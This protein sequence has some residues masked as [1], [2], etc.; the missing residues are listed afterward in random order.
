MLLVATLMLPLGSQAQ[1]LPTPDEA[2]KLI[3]SYLNTQSVMISAPGIPSK[4][5]EMSLCAEDPENPENAKKNYHPAEKAGWLRMIAFGRALEKEGFLTLE[6]GS[7]FEDDFYNRRFKFTGY[8][9]H[10]QNEMNSYVAVMPQQG[11]VLLK[12]GHVGVGQIVSVKAL[13]AEDKKAQ[14]SYTTV[15]IDR[16]PWFTQ[17]VEQ[18]TAVSSMLGG[19]EQVSLTF[20]DGKWLIDDPVFLATVKNPVADFKY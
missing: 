7:F 6:Q 18:F 3:N 11:R 5:H 15:L 16:A 9:M 14:V 12:V 19:K 1:A 8:L 4:L 10:V 20:K 2:A 17:D 13:H